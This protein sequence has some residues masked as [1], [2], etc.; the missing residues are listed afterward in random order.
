M[1]DTNPTKKGKRIYLIYLK[2]IA[3]ILPHQLSEKSNKSVSVIIFQ[4]N[5]NSLFMHYEPVH[6]LLIDCTFL[7]SCEVMDVRH[8]L[9]TIQEE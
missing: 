4:Y 6:H 1:N 2:K 5:H 3:Q 7:I 9:C 8:M